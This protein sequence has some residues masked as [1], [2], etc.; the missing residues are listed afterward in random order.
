[1]TGFTDT[2]WEKNLAEDIAIYTHGVID[3]ENNLTVTLSKSLVD[4]DIEND[5]RAAY[6]RSVFI[7]E[8]KIGVNV[9]NGIVTL[10][11]EVSHYFTKERAYNIAMYTS[12]VVDVIN[13][14]L[15]V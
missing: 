13:N 2:Y 14:I 11:G 3:V 7:D 4:I 1:L 9:N 10:T 12:G 8:G 5:I 6:R 15:V